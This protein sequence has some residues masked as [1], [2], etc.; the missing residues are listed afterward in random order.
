MRIYAVADIHGKTENIEKIKKVI[1][2][3]NP[4]LLVIPGD[5]TQYLSPLKTLGQINSF[6]IPVFGIRGNSDLKYVEKLLPDQKNITLLTPAPV[7]FQ[8]TRFIGINGTIPLP[9]FSKTRFRET[10]FFRLLA[11]GVDAKT[12]LV[13]HP[14]PRGVCDR[15]GNK[16]SAGSFHLR[17]LVENHPPLMVLCGHIHEQAGYQFLKNTLVINCAMNKKSNGAIIDCGNNITLKVKMVSNDR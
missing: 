15:V 7:I 3:E 17:N 16:F 8:D 10:Q 12:I 5:M 4:D 13:A 14:P 9:F 11:P 6:P 1:L 2:Q